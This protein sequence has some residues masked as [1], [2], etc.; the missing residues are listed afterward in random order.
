MYEQYFG[1]TRNPFNMTPDPALLYMTPSHREA[2]AGLAY[3][4][5]QCKGFV[6]MM[7]EA[8]TGKTSLLARNLR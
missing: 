8:G 1:L 7:G 2:L 4:I 5:L 6:T 3:A